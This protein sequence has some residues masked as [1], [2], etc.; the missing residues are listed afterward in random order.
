MLVLSRRCQEAV[1]VG[2]TDGF[3]H[4]LKITVLDIR[5]GRV[6]LGFDV[7]GAVP[8]HRAEIWERILAAESTDDPA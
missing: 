2:G 5:G 7:H 1:V 4:I 3:V 6:R 8:V